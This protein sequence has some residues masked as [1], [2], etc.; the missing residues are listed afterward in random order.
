MS[1]F[2]SVFTHILIV[3]LLSTFTVSRF[4]I[5]FK[6][7]VSIFCF[8]HCDA[9]VRRFLHC[10]RCRDVLYFTI[11][12][13]VY[14]VRSQRPHCPTYHLVTKELAVT[15]GSHWTSSNNRTKPTRLQSR[16]YITIR[17]WEYA[18]K[19][20]D[21]GTHPFGTRTGIS[22]YIVNHAHEYH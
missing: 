17:T 16:A 13:I 21:I 7:S 14:F 11:C 20:I 18:W 10:E 15:S 6:F 1:C 22:L 2:I 12:Y 19:G 4:F 5:K 8:L 3:I 9:P